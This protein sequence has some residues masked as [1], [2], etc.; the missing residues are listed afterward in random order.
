MRAKTVKERWKRWRNETAL[1]K[2]QQRLEIEA[3]KDLTPMP[4]LRKTLTIID[5]ADPDV[6]FPRVIN[7]VNSALFN[8]LS[9]D[10]RK[11]I[12]ECVMGDKCFH[13]VRKGKRLAY[14]LC[15]AQTP[16]SHER[17]GCWGYENG[18]GTFR[19]RD[20]LW[21][22]SNVT[23]PWDNNNRKAHY[24]TDGDLLPLLLSCRRV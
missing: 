9:L 13:I 16:G 20:A 17:D 6:F 3:Q 21:G 12:Y 8:R 1:T 18:D 7:Q 22:R 5:L 10:I 4:S 15:Q 23:L 14:L 11:L 24:R 2:Y 19:F